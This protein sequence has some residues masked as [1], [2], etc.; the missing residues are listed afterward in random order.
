MLSVSFDSLDLSEFDAQSK[1]LEQFH[2][3]DFSPA[4]EELKKMFPESWASIPLRTCPF[5]YSVARELGGSLYSVD[6]S[7]TFQGVRNPE[8]EAA[9][10]RLYESA[11]VT[12]ALR[13]AHETLVIQGSAALLLLPDLAGRIN[14]HVLS[15]YRVK[16]ERASPLVVDERSIDKW[17]VKLPR[18]ETMY[19]AIQE[20]DL[21]VT[22]EEIAWSDGTP[23]FETAANPIGPA[24]P[25]VIL[26]A[27]PSCGGRFFPPVNSDFLS[28]QIALVLSFSDL[29]ASVH[30]QGWG[31]RVI[32]G[33]GME[34]SEVRVG[35]D[36]VLALDEG[37]YQVVSGDPG[38]DG[39]IKR[40]EAYLK[41]VLS[42][43]KVDPSALMSSGAYT[44]ASRIVERADRTQEKL[45]HQR[46]LVRAEQRIYRHLARWTNAIRGIN[47]L[48]VAGITVGLEFHEFTQ[49]FDPLHEAQAGQ[50]R[51]SSGLES[52]V[53]QIAKE[54]GISRA[55]AAEV[56]EE[57]LEVQRKITA[58]ASFGMQISKIRADAGIESP[59]EIIALERGITYAEAAAIF[60]RNIATQRQVLGA[61]GIEAA[62][63]EAG[64]EAVS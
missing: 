13:Y 4:L 33:A 64:L 51:A 24:I 57:N 45:I 53:D 62:P 16:P 6:P 10:R 21:I 19:G 43:N 36:Q 15:P 2:N 44:A 1:A 60:E 52:I 34:P 40:L 28:A 29:G 58:S 20:D 22:R 42:Q 17:R 55:E 23:Y 38:V 18:R 35:P 37:S 12:E 56:L 50:I 48:P 41:I 54:R 47:A 11:R 26:R 9:I 27:A 25:I 46:E 32:V 7:R 61:S 39:Y 59:I 49:P 8:T 3:R 63:T 14:I 30:N 31:Q 5:V